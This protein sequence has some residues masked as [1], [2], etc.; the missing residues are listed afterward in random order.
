MLKKSNFPFHFT[1]YVQKHLILDLGLDHE[2]MFPLMKQI[3]RRYTLRT[4]QSDEWIKDESGIAFPINCV[5]DKHVVGDSLDRCFFEVIE[6]E[7]IVQ[8]RERNVIIK[9]FDDYVVAIPCTGG[10]PKC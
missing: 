1:A 8:S 3:F 6:I 2:T 5:I 7:K 9:I 4:I 10:R